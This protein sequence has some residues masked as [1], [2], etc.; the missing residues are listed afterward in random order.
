M[1]PKTILSTLMIAGFASLAA[2]QPAAVAAKPPS[3]VPG[4]EP[5][6]ATVTVQVNA[7]N[8]GVVG[9]GGAPVPA[10]RRLVMEFVS[11]AVLVPPGQTALV[12]LYGLVNGAGLPFTIPVTFVGT[13]ASYDE[14]RGTH[15]VRVY[16]DGNGVNGPGVG[17]LRSAPSGFASCSVTISGYLIG[18]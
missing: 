4:A 1:Q 12:S 9:N 2:L 13:T 17:C 14:Y 8:S 11:V 7:P 15:Q 16:H 3:T 10:D 18:K 5:Y 6:Q